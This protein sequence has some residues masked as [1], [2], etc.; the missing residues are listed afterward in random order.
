MPTDISISPNFVS[1][2][3]DDLDFARHLVLDLKQAGASVWMD[4]LD[5][6][7][8][9]LWD[10]AIEDAVN[11]CSRI[12]LI[13]SPDSVSSAEVMA[14]VSLAMDEHKEIIPVLFRECRIPFRLRRIEYVDL[15]S[16]ENYACGLERLIQIIGGECIAQPTPAEL[17][18]EEEAPPAVVPVAPPVEPFAGERRPM[19][20]SVQYAEEHFADI[21]NA[22]SKGAVVEIA[23]PGKRAFD[24][25]DAANS[26]SQSQPQP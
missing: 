2:S 25:E 18:G 14:E 26:R 12:I 21:V 16:A 3:R 10:N 4:K 7:A 17:L 5:I 6:R 8:G 20:V 1:Y 24:A 13:M 11:R 15:S 9:Q 22:A 19:K 23:L